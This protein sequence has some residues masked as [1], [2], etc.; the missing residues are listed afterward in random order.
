MGPFDQTYTGG[1]KPRFMLESVFTSPLGLITAW[2]DFFHQL[3]SLWSFCPWWTFISPHSGSLERM[4]AEQK[5]G[6][7]NFSFEGDVNNLGQNG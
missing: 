3:G 2:V 5:P 4:W 7:R 6:Y 1:K